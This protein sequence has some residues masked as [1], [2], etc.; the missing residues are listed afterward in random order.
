[1]LIQLLFQYPQAITQV[2]RNTPTWVWGL[3][4][5]LLA[6]GLTQLRK[7]EISLARMAI[8]PIAMVGLSVWGSASAFGASPLFGYVM[9]AWAICAAL[10]LGL[11][12]TRAPLP[13]MRYDV[14]TRIF[15]VPGSWTPLLLILAI[16]MVKYV[17]GADV[18]MQPA[19]AHDGTYT[20]VV[21]ALYGLFSGVFAGRTARL[22]L[23][24][25]RS[26]T[27]ATPAFTT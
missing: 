15:T 21:G 8:T 6:L 22:W 2:V 11:I 16:F 3:L 14:A 20:L 13:G 25:H 18:A 27:A 7:R 24:A 4:A 1:M 17:V 10:M 5:A 9:L 12:G 19:L 26:A 23:I